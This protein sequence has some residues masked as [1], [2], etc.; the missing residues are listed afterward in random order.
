[1]SVDQKKQYFNGCIEVT[2]TLHHH[3]DLD[4]D[5]YEFFICTEIVDV[6]IGDL[7]FRDDKQFENIDADDGEQN[8][9]NAVRKKFIEKQNEKKNAMKLLC[10]EDDAPIYTVTI[11][12]V[13]CFDLA[14]DYVGI[15]LSFRQTA[16]A[17]QKAK[18]HTKTTKLAGLNDYIVDQYTHVL[19]VVTLQQITGI[20]DNESIWAMLLVG[21]GSAHR[22]QSFFDLR[23]RVCYRGELVNL[24][25]VAMPMFERHS[26]VN[27]FNL[28]AKFMDML[29]I[30]WLAKLIGVSM[31]GKNTITGHHAGVVTRLVDCADNDVLH[32]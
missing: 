7:F 9:A 5:M 21:D 1:M 23:V 20:L 13:L 15:S 11:K 14:M 31:D 12:D 28:I 25:L 30:K 27:I 26:A 8:P 6:I 2:N 32:I 4:K 18:D 19:V 24:H 22:G 16:A 10:K 17:I 29:Y 3:F